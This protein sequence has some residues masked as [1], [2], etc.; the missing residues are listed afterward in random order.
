LSIDTWISVVLS[1]CVSY[2]SACRSVYLPLVQSPRRFIF[3]HSSEHLL[4]F[5][6]SSNLL[7]APANRL[8]LLK[9]EMAKEGKEWMF[10]AH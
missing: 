2:L 8:F 3:C 9:E 7:S 1:V 4:I 6:K 5:T 10:L